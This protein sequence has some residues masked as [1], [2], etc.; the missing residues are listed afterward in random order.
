IL[1]KTTG[2]N[3][4]EHLLA[5]FKTLNLHPRERKEHHKELNEFPYVN[6]ALFDT[7]LT[8]VPPTTNALRNALLN[9][10]SAYDWSDISPV[11][12]GSLFQAVMDDTERRSLGAHF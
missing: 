6:G 9:A 7:R 1:N 8:H 11:I 5:L 10:C 12:F 2:Q 4:G 3:L